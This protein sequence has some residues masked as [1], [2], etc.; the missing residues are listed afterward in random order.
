MEMGHVIPYFSLVLSKT[1]Y[2]IS[3]TSEHLPISLKQDLLSR[4]TGGL[5]LLISIEKSDTVAGETKLQVGV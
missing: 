5:D 3:E 2:T 4:T 1:R